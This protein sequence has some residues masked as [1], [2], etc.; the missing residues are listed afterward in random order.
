MEGMISVQIERPS[1]STNSSTLESGGDGSSSS[2]QR[3]CDCEF[4]CKCERSGVGIQKLLSPQSPSSS[5]SPTS[6]F[7]LDNMMKTNMNATHQTS[8]FDGLQKSRSKKQISW[9]DEDD[10]TLTLTLNDNED[11]AE[12]VVV[13]ADKSDNFGFTE[14]VNDIANLTAKDFGMSDFVESILSPVA[15]AT[16]SMC[17]PH[18]SAFTDMLQDDAVATVSGALSKELHD[19]IFEYFPEEEATAAEDVGEGGV[20]REVIIRGEDVDVDIIPGK[21]VD[22]NIAPCFRIP[23]T[24]DVKDGATTPPDQDPKRVARGREVSRSKEGETMTMM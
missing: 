2:G 1:T 6:Q 24:I 23:S 12:D 18:E 10:E 22:E 9:S 13:C 7:E 14:L 21:D 19:L 16:E 3:E 15:D 5:R 8:D 17:S 11:K 4:E 20:V